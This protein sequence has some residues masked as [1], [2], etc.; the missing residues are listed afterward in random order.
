MLHKNDAARRIA[1]LGNF[2]GVT[3]TPPDPRKVVARARERPP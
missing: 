3:S 1:T 2:D